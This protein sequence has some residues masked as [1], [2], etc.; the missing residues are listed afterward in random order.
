[1]DD[2]LG[3]TGAYVLAWRPAANGKAVLAYRHEGSAEGVAG[4]QGFFA[5]IDLN[6]QTAVRIDDIPYNPDFYLFQYQGYAVEGTEIYL[7]QAPVGQNGNI[8][9]VET[10]TGEVT[11]GAE[12]I[13]AEGSHFIGAW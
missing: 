3:I 7:T 6:A 10:E 2:A 9:V 5:L 11:Q 12:L 13:N 8:Y 4:A 1:M